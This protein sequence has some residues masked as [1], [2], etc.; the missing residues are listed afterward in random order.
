MATHKLKMGLY[1]YLRV[2]NYL[3]SSTKGDVD[4]T[5]LMM[6]TEGDRLIHKLTPIEAAQYDGDQEDIGDPTTD[7]SGP[8]DGH[9][10]VPDVD[11]ERDHA[12]VKYTARLAVVRDRLDLMGYTLPRVRQYF[13]DSLRHNIDDIINS[14]ENPRLAGSDEM[15]TLR[16]RKIEFLRGVDFDKWLEAFAFVL[17]HDLKPGYLLQDQKSSDLPPLVRL[18]IGDLRC[19]GVWTPFD[20]ARW[21]IRAVVEVARH[22]LELVYDLTEL[23]FSEQLY[24]DEDLC[25]RARRQ[26]ADECTFNHRLVVLTEGSTDKWAIEGTFRLLYPHLVDYYSFMDFGPAKVQGGAAAL[27]SVVKGSERSYFFRPLGR[28]PG[29]ETNHLPSEGRRMTCDSNASISRRPSLTPLLYD[30]STRTTS[31]CPPFQL[32]VSA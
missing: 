12:I 23:F 19:E 25:G 24:L 21:M 13:Q 7:E 6:F 31:G 4:P 5:A 8:A 22:D 2:G 17:D 1:A 14:N 15:R 16:Y 3:L 27:V 9:E 32:I 10:S 20:D 18:L 28:L 29:M 26:A 11:N 30:C